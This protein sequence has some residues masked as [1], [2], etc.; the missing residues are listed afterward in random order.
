M[1]EIGPGVYAITATP[2][3]E[4]G[5]LDED[6]I[7]ALVHRLFLE[8]PPA[9]RSTS[10]TAQGAGDCLSAGQEEASSADTPSSFSTPAT[11]VQA[12][13]GKVMPSRARRAASSRARSPGMCTGPPS[14]TGFALLT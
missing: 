11:L 8:S 7:A 6:S 14:G 3:D 2:F 10:T 9:A 4:Q 5:R 13:S 12:C 1:A